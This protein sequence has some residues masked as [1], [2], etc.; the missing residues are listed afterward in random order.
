[1]IGQLFYQTLFLALVTVPLAGEVVRYR[2]SLPEWFQPFPVIVPLE[3][4]DDKSGESANDK[5]A[6]AGCVLPFVPPLCSVRVASSSPVYSFVSCR[7][8]LARGPPRC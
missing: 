6:V 7:Q 1:M 4:E 3:D 5:L 8:A 2:P